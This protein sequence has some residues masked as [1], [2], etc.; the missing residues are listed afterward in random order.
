MQSEEIRTGGTGANQAREI[1][2]LGSPRKGSLFSARL[3]QTLRDPLQ[4][5]QTIGIMFEFR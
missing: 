3:P 4:R 5:R 1:A 2:F